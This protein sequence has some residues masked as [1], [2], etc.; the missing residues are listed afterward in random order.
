[1]TQVAVPDS[2][3]A[4]FDG[5]QL[6]S[7]KHSFTFK[8]DGDDFVVSMP[9][10]E[11]QVRQMAGGINPRDEPKPPMV[12]R[13]VVMTTGSHNIQFYW[14]EGVRSGEPIRLPFIWFVEHQ[15]LVPAED[16]YLQRP[17]LWDEYDNHYFNPGRGLWNWAC[18]ECHSLAARPGLDPLSGEMKTEVA[19][20]GISC[21]HCHGPGEAHVQRHSTNKNNAGAVL[22]G[23][24]DPTIVHPSRVSSKT[25]THICGRCHSEYLHPDQDRV[26]TDGLKFQAGDDL[27]DWVNVSWFGDGT[28]EWVG[29]T[30]WPDGT[31][32]VSGDEFLGTTASPC[33]LKGELSCLSCHSMHDS[34]P[35]DQLAIGMGRNEAC[36]QCHS[37]MRPDVSAHTHHAA[38]SSGSNCYNCHM[39][40]TA[41][42]FLSAQR[43]HRI[44]S[45]NVENT[46][47][48]G[49]P[50][51]CNLCHLDQ[52]LE[53]T[54]QHLT[55]WFEQ[56][57]VDLQE[58]HRLTSASIMWLLK[59]NAVQRAIIASHY[60]WSEALEI[61]GN[62]WQSRQLARLLVDPYS[63]VRFIAHDSL[64]T[65]PGFEEFRYDF[66]DDP[67]K[68]SDGRHN[69]L[70]M[71]LT[72][73][74]AIR[75]GNGRR[76]LFDNRGQPLDDIAERLLKQ[77][78]DAP[79]ELYE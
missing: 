54:A 17:G 70:E 27:E 9:D 15:R 79:V 22:S 3:L 60:S 69:A 71:S 66:I 28:A 20:F 5:E 10:P 32:R 6:E 68:R 42:A 74:Q 26:L 2:V 56:P 12:D 18:S 13:R 77:R 33:Y 39:P 30:Y 67:H 78:D 44:D 57:K 63:A 1:M 75:S 35:Q 31:Q 43:T 11:W 59:G 46:I 19:E 24:P 36:L 21:E 40:R 34:D 55:E 29:R 61:S 51:A 41:Y 48:S 50:N 4:S 49:K 14:V 38:D 53:W 76:V 58:E 8:R 52:T 37:E 65:L 73:P 47:S 25:A 7:W 45:P 72:M 62:D 23:E 64:T 16:A